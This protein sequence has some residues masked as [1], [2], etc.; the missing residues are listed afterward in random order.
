VT[1]LVRAVPVRHTASLVLTAVALLAVLGAWFS[2]SSYVGS[3]ASG[4]ARGMAYA[5]ALAILCY[6]LVLLV[7]RPSTKRDQ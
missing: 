1:A 2:G 4:A 5:T 3:H 7:A 6:A